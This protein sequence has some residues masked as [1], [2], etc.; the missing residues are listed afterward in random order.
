[1]KQ[2][3]GTGVL[4]KLASTIVETIELLGMAIIIGVGHRTNEGAL[5]PAIKE[6]AVLDQDDGAHE[7]HPSGDSARPYSAGLVICTGSV[8]GYLRVSS[9]L[10]RRSALKATRPHSC[11]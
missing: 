8:Y 4:I 10:I 11:R 7:H 5:A 1:M 9:H 3:V 2:T 6:S